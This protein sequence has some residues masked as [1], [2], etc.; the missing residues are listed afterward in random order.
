MSRLIQIHEVHVY[1]DHG[2]SRLNCVCRCK[3]GLLNKLSPAI[4]ILAGE[5]VL[6]S[7]TPGPTHASAL[8]ASRQS[9]RM[10]SA[11]VRTGFQTTL[12]GITLAP[13]S[14]PAICLN[15][16]PLCPEPLCHRDADFGDKPHFKRFKLILY[17][18]VC[19][20]TVM[21]A[22]LPEH[23][24]ATLQLCCSENDPHSHSQQR[25]GIGFIALGIVGVEASWFAKFSQRSGTLVDN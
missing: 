1:V 9:R 3:N 25:G 18:S 20:G 2:R 12:S 13:S 10:A 7:R 17:P 22:L 4:H 21:N 6:H 23:A 19:C 8:L 5:K 24:F 11:V 14:E 16:L 15:A